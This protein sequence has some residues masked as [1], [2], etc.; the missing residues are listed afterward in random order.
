MSLT[1]WTIVGAAGL[2]VVFFVVALTTLAV[3][4]HIGREI[5]AQHEG[6]LGPECRTARTLSHDPDHPEAPAQVE[7][8]VSTRAASLPRAEVGLGK[9]GP[10][11]IQQ[12]H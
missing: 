2:L 6:I 11:G 4:G 9:L 7:T 10:S 3:L 1:E 5:S 12:S 8:K